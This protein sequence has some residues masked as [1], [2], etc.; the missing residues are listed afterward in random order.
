[1]KKTLGSVFL[2]RTF[3]QEHKSPLASG[4]R[5]RRMTTSYKE[6]LRQTGQC[7]VQTK[8]I[9]MEP[10][11]H[12]ELSTVLIVKP[13][14]PLRKMDIVLYESDDHTLILHRIWKLYPDRLL[15][16]TDYG[17]TR[18]WIR[19]DQVLGV[20]AGF[21]RDDSNHFTK[22]GSIEE[23][24]YCGKLHLRLLSKKMKGYD[25]TDEK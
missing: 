17:L 3:V 5:G 8:G 6:E 13:D 4:M 21:F 12:A 23:R 24:M 20:A 1:M 14:R 22:A 16:R 10:L 19:R 11:L 7:F 9:S 18:E 2:L 15:L 25:K